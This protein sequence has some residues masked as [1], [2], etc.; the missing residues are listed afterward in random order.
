MDW[1]AVF[2]NPVMAKALGTLIL[3]ISGIGLQRLAAQTMHSRK[4]IPRRVRRRWLVTI[5]NLLSMVVLAGI[6]VIWFE[7]L[8]ALAA[9]I[10]VI[11][12]AFV[13]AT[14]EIWINMTG[15]L[16]RSGAHFFSIGDRI[17]LGDYR[18]DVIDHRFSGVTIL[19]IGPGSKSHQYSGRAVLIPNSKFLSTP[20]VN[21]TYM[22]DYVF[23]HITV[24]I[25]SSTNWQTAEQ[26]L[27]EA[28]NQVCAPYLEKA[29]RH[30]RE[31]ERHHSLDA[32]GVEPRVQIQLPEPE[33][34]NLVLRFPIPARRRGRLEQELIR[35]YLLNLA[36]IKAAERAE[37][38][39][40]EQPEQQPHPAEERIAQV[41]TVSA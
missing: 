12:A 25:K 32:P 30:M 27:L 10:L 3:L 11:G 14:K 8:R 18:G 34:L 41:K 35:R 2:Q 15:F 9:A 29:R 36:E 1:H 21:E 23:H 26:A 4:K 13:L 31:L 28:A 40:D 16:F 7:Q 39:K 37:S 24:P 5:R 33:R 17:E 19:E 38:E 22:K 20:V 6:V